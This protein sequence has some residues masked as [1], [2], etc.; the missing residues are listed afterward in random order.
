MPVSMNIAKANKLDDF[1][2]LMPDIEKELCHYSSFFFDKVVYCCCDNPDYSNFYKYFKH[3]FEKLKLKLLVASCKI[4][5]ASGRCVKFNGVEELEYSDV[6]GSI[7]SN[8]FCSRVAKSDIIVTNPPFSKSKMLISY[9]IKHGKK[10]ILVGNRNL[11]TSDKMFSLFMEDKI[12]LGYGF[13]GA[14]GRFYIPQI[15]YGHYSKDVNRDAQNLVRFRNVVWFTNLDINVPPKVRSYTKKYDS[16]YYPIYDNYD[17]INVDKI[18]DIPYDYFGEMGVPITILEG[19]D[20]HTFDI[21]GIDRN[22]EGNTTGKR[23]SVNG[24]DKYV[25]IIIKRKQA[26]EQL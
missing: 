16:L 5:L 25:R 11:I 3:N 13:E 20:Y 21:M 6:D 7:G 18:S 24:K 15:L 19:F 10:F 4:G 22:M 14:T 9:L 17:A 12:R 26:N 2:T 23:F 1:Y 8:W